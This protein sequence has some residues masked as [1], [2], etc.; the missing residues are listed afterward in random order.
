[1]VCLGAAFPEHHLPDEDANANRK[2]ICTAIS[3]YQT[4]QWVS[5]GGALPLLS[6]LH[7]LSHLLDHDL[8]G[9]RKLC[10]SLSLSLYHLCRGRRN[11]GRTR[12]A[13]FLL[14]RPTRRRPQRRWRQR[15]GRG[16]LPSSSSFTNSA[17]ALSFALSFAFAPSS[18]TADAARRGAVVHNE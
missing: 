3:A 11:D 4:K 16:R 7:A 2:T 6:F 15:Q 13:S 17:F 14:P 8:G 1:M 12:A 10:L 5:L 9:A 18:V